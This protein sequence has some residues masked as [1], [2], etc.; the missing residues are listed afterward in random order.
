MNIKKFITH[1]DTLFRILEFS[2]PSIV[3]N[4][5][6]INDMHTSVSEYIKYIHKNCACKIVVFCVN[7]EL[8]FYCFEEFMLKFAFLMVNKL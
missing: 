5:Y 8:R 3:N 7:E 4:A 1:L 6:L 2:Q